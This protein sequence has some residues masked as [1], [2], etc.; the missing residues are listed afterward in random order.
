MNLNW[1]NVLGYIYKPRLCITLPLALLI[2]TYSFQNMQRVVYTVREVEH[3]VSFF[4]RV[5]LDGI[6]FRVYIYILNWYIYFF[7]GSSL[8]ISHDNI[9]ILFITTITNYSFSSLKHLHHFWFEIF[10]HF[11]LN[12]NHQVS[13]QLRTNHKYGF[14]ISE[15]YLNK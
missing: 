14:L 3:G 4:V 2:Y 12:E 6:A 1:F 13:L 15:K 11:W 5:N 8:E 9:F 10:S 7:I